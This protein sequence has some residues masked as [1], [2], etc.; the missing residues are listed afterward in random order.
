MSYREEKG[1]GLT[2]ERLAA[3]Y[4]PDGAWDGQHPVFLW[5]DWYQSVAKRETICGYWDWV[6]VQLER[7]EV[8]Q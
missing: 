8:S 6:V 3:K 7:E 5:W 1:Y 2:A 4:N